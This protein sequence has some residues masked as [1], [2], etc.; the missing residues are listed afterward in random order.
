MSGSLNSLNLMKGWLHLGKGEFENWLCNYRGF[1]QTFAN[2]VTT[3]EV[4]N[5]QIHSK[6]QFHKTTDPVSLDSSTVSQT[7]Q[8]SWDG[9][10]AKT[11]FLLEIIS[12][13]VQT[14]KHHKGHGFSSTYF[15]TLLDCPYLEHH[16]MTVRPKKLDTHYAF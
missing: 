8:I 2:F 11:I 14:V 12:R 13:K 9:I 4:A 15:M 6:I 3:H 1:W 16:K 10:E 7:V 5:F